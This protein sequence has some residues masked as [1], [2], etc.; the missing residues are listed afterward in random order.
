MHDVADPASSSWKCQLCRLVTRSFE[1]TRAPNCGYE[2]LARVMANNLPT[3]RMDLVS[4]VTLANHYRYRNRP[5]FGTLAKNFSS[6]KCERKFRN[7]WQP[8]LGLKRTR[9]VAMQ[10][11]HG[12]RV[13][14]IANEFWDDGAKGLEIRELL[15]CE[16][17]RSS[18][19][20]YFC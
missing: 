16:F 8:S 3:T 10:S 20:F 11:W 1:E 18:D 4:I 17:E 6:Q 15:T 2:P 9:R 14:F 19:N 12:F 13:T 5:N 7:R